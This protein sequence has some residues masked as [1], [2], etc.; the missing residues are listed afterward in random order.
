MDILFKTHVTTYVEPISTYT[1]L[2]LHTTETCV[3]RSWWPN[4]V[5]Y[6]FLFIHFTTKRSY[7]HVVHTY[8]YRWTQVLT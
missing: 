3:Q 8:N 2:V 7:T 4:H 1:R 6:Y 5:V